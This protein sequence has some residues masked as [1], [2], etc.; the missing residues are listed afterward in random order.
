MNEDGL[1]IGTYRYNAYGKILEIKVRYWTDINDTFINEC[2]EILNLNPIR[3]KSYYYDTESNMYYLNNR[4]LV[5]FLINS[6][7][8]KLHN[9][10]RVI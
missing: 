6:M 1:L 3:Y 7:L 8:Y 10:K 2:N 9:I 5:I 4:Y